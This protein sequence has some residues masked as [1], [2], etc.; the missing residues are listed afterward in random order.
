MGNTITKAKTFREQLLMME[1]GKKVFV[2]Y[3]QF[4]TSYVRRIAKELNQKG[5]SFAVNECQ[6]DGGIMITRIR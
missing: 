4:T 5:Y 3:T 2:K 6:V 1:I